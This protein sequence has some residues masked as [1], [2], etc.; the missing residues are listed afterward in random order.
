MFLVERVWIIRA[1][2]QLIRVKRYNYNTL[3]LSCTLAT[4]L[5]EVLRDSPA[6][7]GLRVHVNERGKRSSSI[8]GPTEHRAY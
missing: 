1:D 4:A 6:E 7:R 3:Y 5:R 8:S 2:E